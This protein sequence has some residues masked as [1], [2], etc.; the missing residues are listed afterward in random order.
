MGEISKIK[1]VQSIEECLLNIG[2]L[3]KEPKQKDKRKTGINSDFKELFQSELER[4]RDEASN[5]KISI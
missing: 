5:Q 3:I 2:T 4:L 1:R